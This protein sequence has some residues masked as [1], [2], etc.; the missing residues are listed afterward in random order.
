MN[1]NKAVR[2]DNGVIK[3]FTTLY[4]FGINKITEVINEI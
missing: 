2:Q 1:R 3:M 4:G